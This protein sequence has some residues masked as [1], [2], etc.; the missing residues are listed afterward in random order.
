MLNPSGSERRRHSG[1]RCASNLSRAAGAVEEH[2]AAAAP[3]ISLADE[4]TEYLAGGA[5][6][7]PSAAAVAPEAHSAAGTPLRQSADGVTQAAGVCSAAPLTDMLRCA[8][9]VS[10]AAGRLQS[11]SGHAKPQPLRVPPSLRCSPSAE[12]IADLMGPSLSKRKRK[13]EDGFTHMEV[14]RMRIADQRRKRLRGFGTSPSPLKRPGRRW[15]QGPSS[16]LDSRWCNGGLVGC[17][18][19]RARP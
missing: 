8:V 1:R 9:A 2:S 16:R 15:M 6:A 7:P 5:A 18:R 4:I 12:D 3:V 11:N 17:R 14:R 19:Q 10:S 13:R